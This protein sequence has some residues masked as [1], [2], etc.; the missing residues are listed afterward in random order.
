ARGVP[1]VGMNKNNELAIHGK[2]K[3][4][5][6]LSCWAKSCSLSKNW[7]NYE[8]SARMKLEKNGNEI[9]R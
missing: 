9:Q 2:T 1:A 8:G 4:K 5:E 3:S 7:P 6:L